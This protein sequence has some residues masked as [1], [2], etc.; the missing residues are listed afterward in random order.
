MK[1]LM[2]KARTE[3]LFHSHIKIKIP[4]NYEDKIFDELFGIMEQ[5]DKKYNSYSEFS[6]FDLINKN[7]GK[8][9]DVDSITIEILEAARKYSDFFDGLEP[10]AA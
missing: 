3:Y 9:T 4:D 7:A 6:Y 10:I 5:V 1:R 2:Y 8:Y